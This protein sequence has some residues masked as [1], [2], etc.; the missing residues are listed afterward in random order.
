VLGMAQKVQ[1]L[2]IDDLDGGEADSTV[3]F[4]LDGTEYEIDLSAKN[5]EA[6]RKAL[7]RYLD[8][9]GSCRSSRAA[10]SSSSL[11][12]SSSPSTGPYRHSAR[13]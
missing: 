10:C 13:W 8:V 5:A 12:A 11:T 3:R 1:A 9:A 6:L 4:G 7:G 2:L